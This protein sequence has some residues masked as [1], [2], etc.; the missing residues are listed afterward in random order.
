MHSEEKGF[1]RLVE[2]MRRLRGPGGCPWDAEQSHESATLYETG[3]LPQ[4]RLTL[5]SALA[6]YRV[7]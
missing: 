6:A 2:I 3:I 4:A 7:G 1:V 5:E